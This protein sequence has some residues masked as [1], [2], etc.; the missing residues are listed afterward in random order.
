MYIN[1]FI[2]PICVYIGTIENISEKEEKLIKFG[3]TNNLHQRIL[4]HKK[5]YN[6][7]IFPC[8]D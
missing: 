7:F 6:N 5:D 8:K 2:I 4:N 1:Q 3:S